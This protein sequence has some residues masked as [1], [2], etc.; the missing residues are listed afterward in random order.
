MILKE[1]LHELLL[2]FLQSRDQ[3]RSY[4]GKRRYGN[5]RYKCATG[6]AEKGATLEGL[7]D[8]YRGTE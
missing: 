7:A 5:N 1:A 6:D 3:N 8:G 4:Y 2:F